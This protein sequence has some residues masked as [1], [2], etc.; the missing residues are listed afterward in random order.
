MLKSL[1]LAV[2]LLCAGTASYADNP[3]NTPRAPIVVASISLQ[4]QTATIPETS[5]FTPTASGDFRVSVYVDW[6][7]LIDPGD[8]GFITV[9]WSDDYQQAVQRFLGF[10]PLFTNAGFATD[11]FSVHALANSPITYTVGQSG[12]PPFS[13]A[14]PYNLYV[15]VEQL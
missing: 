12:N 9:A 10:G 5:L 6:S 3:H 11:T 7:P 8:A 13:L 14:T 15:T 4:N 1:L 2:V